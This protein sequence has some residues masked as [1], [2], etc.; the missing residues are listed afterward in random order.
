M[1]TKRAN[2]KFSQSILFCCLSRFDLCNQLPPT[3]IKCSHDPVAVATLLTDMSVVWSNR[4]MFHSNIV[5]FQWPDLQSWTDIRGFSK[6]CQWG[7]KGQGNLGKRGGMERPGR[8]EGGG[9]LEPNLLLPIPTTPKK[10]KPGIYQRSS[11]WLFSCHH[12]APENL[13]HFGV[14]FFK[15]NSSQQ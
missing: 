11:S 13:K 10:P 7:W 8:G 14:F 15:Q 4:F 3:V 1:A 2:N 12:C 5:W 9:V 6:T